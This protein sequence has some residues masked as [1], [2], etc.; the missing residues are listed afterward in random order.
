MSMM[1]WDSVIA[2]K[3]NKNSDMMDDSF[4]KDGDPFTLL[5]RTLDE[6]S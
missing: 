1:S 2:N 6:E 4:K 5:K 3:F